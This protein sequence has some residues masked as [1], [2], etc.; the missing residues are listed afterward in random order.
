MDSHHR[1]SI[2]ALIILLVVVILYAHERTIQPMPTLTPMVHVP[3]AGTVPSPIHQGSTDTHQV[4]FTFDGGEGN[5]SA[6]QILAVLERHHIHGTFFLTG[7]WVERNP[8]LVRRIHAAGHDIYNHSYS[9]PHLPSLRWSEIAEQLTLMDASVISLIGSSTKPY[10]RPPFGEYN[11]DVLAVAARNGYRAVM[12][13]VDV[14]DWMETEG[15]TDAEAKARIYANIDPGSIFLMHIGDTITGRI[16]DEV[17]TE[18]ESRGYRI[19]PLS[20]GLL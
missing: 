7:K 11:K 4:I 13:T 2:S 6:E 20:Q 17:F 9:H 14:G 10:F 15:F 3:F 1:R 16:L 18:V 5:Q 19:V 12:W 8:E